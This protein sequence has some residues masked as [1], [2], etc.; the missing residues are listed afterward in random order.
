VALNGNRLTDLKASGENGS[1]DR[2]NIDQ[3]VSLHQTMDTSEEE[4]K[5]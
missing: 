5:K 1:M 3:I 4:K 2:I